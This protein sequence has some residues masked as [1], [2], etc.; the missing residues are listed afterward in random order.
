M[1]NFTFNLF[2]YLVL[3]YFSYCMIKNQSNMSQNCENKIAIKSFKLNL[4]L[5]QSYIEGDIYELSKLP[6]SIK[7]L[8]QLTS[9]ESE[10]DG[11]SFGKFNPTMVDLKKWQE[12]LKENENNICW[13]DAKQKVYI[14]QE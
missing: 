7:R 5:I 4:M 6:E 1:N 3:V 8:E 12:W 13:D 14:K 9:I 10:S 2:I 11:N